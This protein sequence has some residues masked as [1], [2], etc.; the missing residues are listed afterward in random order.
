MLVVP[1]QLSDHPAVDPAAAL[2][3]ERLPYGQENGEVCPV[4]G[5]SQGRFG[6][7]FARDGVRDFQEIQRIQR[8]RVYHSAK[9]V[10][11]SSR[12]VWADFDN[13]SRSSHIASVAASQ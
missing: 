5:G 7:A 6:C 11:S 4:D 3:L 9:I 13:L 12:S 1:A 10:T 8:L 2:Y